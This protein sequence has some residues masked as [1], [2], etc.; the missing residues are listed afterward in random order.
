[1]IR[2]SRSDPNPYLA[3][4]DPHYIEQC[5]ASRIFG[6]R[7]GSGSILNGSGSAEKQI[8]KIHIQTLNYGFGFKSGSVITTYPHLL[9]KSVF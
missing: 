5:F 2:K 7:P 3:D 4:P 8:L 1:M 9:G 6:F